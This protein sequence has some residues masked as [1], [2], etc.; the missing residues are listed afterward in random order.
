MPNQGIST[1]AIQVHMKHPLFKAGALTR[2]DQ[3]ADNFKIEGWGQMNLI[4]E[5]T[6]IGRDT[7]IRRA[8]GLKDWKKSTISFDADFGKVDSLAEAIDAIEADPMNRPLEIEVWYTPT[9]NKKDTVK[10]YI[11][12]SGSP[13]TVAD[14]TM[15]QVVLTYT[16]TIVKTR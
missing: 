11:E 8:Q 10:F 14:I 16:E 4:L 3:I 13:I 9:G 6:G 15:Y 7:R 2:I 5:R 12:E 1:T